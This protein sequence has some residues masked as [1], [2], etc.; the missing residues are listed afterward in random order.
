ML[1]L[2]NFCIL[3]M[4]PPSFTVTKGDIAHLL[5]LLDPNLLLSYTLLPSHSYQKL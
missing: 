4:S 2:F 5:E 3:P 1:T